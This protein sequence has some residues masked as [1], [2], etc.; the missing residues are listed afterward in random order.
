VP[1][2]KPMVPKRQGKINMLDLSDK[3]EILDLSKGVMPMDTQSLLQSKIDDLV[4]WN[5]KHITKVS[6]FQQF[7]VS[8]SLPEMFFICMCVFVFVY[9]LSSFPFSVLLNT[10]DRRSGEPVPKDM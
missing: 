10:N 6:D 8:L 2:G 3:V 5:K 1:P 4:L 9:M 7:P